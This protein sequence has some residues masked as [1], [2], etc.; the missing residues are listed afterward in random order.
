MKPWFIVVTGGPGSGKSALGRE[1]ER[2]LRIPF[3]S[4]D[5]VRAGLLAT[6]G[7]WTNEMTEMPPRE[8]AVEAFTRLVEAIAALGISAAL[9]FVV[10]PDRVSAMRRIEAAGNCVVVRTE[11]EGAAERAQQRDLAEPLLNRRDV[12]AALGYESVAGYVDDQADHGGVVR[13][14][15]QT[16]FDL[17]LLAVRTDDGYDPSLPSIVDWI[18]A[19]TRRRSR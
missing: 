18:V 12:L 19:Q 16:E 15:M 3:I 13:T 10:M 5:H 9:E 2:A 14:A 1:L 8:A 11:C 6:A 7:L 4:R 17:P